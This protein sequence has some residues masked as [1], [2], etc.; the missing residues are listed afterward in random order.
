MQNKK[1]SRYGFKKIL[2]C[3]SMM[4]LGSVMFII[5]ALAAAP[6]ASTTMFNLISLMLSMFKYV[7]AAIFVWAIIQFILATKRSDADSKADAVQTAVCGIAMMSIKT[8]VVGLGITDAI[9]GAD[10]FN[11]ESLRLSRD[12]ES[13]KLLTKANQILNLM[14]KCYPILLTVKL[15][16]TSQHDKD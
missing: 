14:T 7:G 6:N 5:P 10:S 3:L 12:L 11:D 15:N 13:E 2:V 4:L 8:I 16:L 1:E 9:D